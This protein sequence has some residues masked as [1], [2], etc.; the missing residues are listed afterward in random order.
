MY[1]EIESVD[2]MVERVHDGLADYRGDWELICVDDGSRDGTGQR[3][4]EIAARVGPH[5]RVI[6][7]RRNFGQ[8]AAMQAGFD[9]ARGELIATLDGDL[10]NDPADIPRMVDELLARDLDLLQ[11]WRRRRQDDLVMRKIPSRIANAMIGKVT[12]VALHDYGCS[13]K[14]YRAEVIKEVTLLGE[15]HRFIPVW[16]AG[17]TAPQR[18]GETEVTHQARQFGTSK[19][20][21]SRTFRVLLDLLAAFFFLRFG[22]RPG[23]FFG[24]IGI[25]FGVLGGLMMTHLL[26]VKFVLGEDIGNRPLLFVSILLLVASV[27]L[28]TTGVLAELLTRT[29]Y[30][31]G[32]RTHHRIRWASDPE[33]AGWRSS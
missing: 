3:L 8:T 12:G 15:M 16:V 13:L 26:V 2:P 20:G 7:L 29:F 1:Q 23:H 6:C 33:T 11:G 31:S 27:Q 4:R 19:Y 5:M 24:S 28:L 30:A 18:I 9:A 14:V 25:L 22:S 32:E 17:V 10:Q 21:I